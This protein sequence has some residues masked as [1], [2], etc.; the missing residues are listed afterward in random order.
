[1]AKSSKIGK[2]TAADQVAKLEKLLKPEQITKCKDWAKA[3]PN[4]VRYAFKCLDRGWKKVDGLTKKELATYE[5]LRSLPGVPNA[6]KTADAWKASVIEG[7]KAAA[8]AK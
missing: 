4:E 8:A 1:M 2:H 3:E 5:Q 6:Q 7:H